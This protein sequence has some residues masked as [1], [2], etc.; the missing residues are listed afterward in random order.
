MRKQTNYFW[1]AGLGFLCF[2]TKIDLIQAQITSDRTLSTEV[3]T[4]NNLDFT[5]INGNRVGNNLF[6]SFRELSVP[7]GGSAFFSNDLNVQNIISRVTGGSISNIDGLLK[8]NG[9][10]NLFLI[11]PNGIIFGQNASLNINGSFFVST[12]NN[13]IFADGTQFS[14]TNLQTP[15]LLTVSVPIG[16]QFG[17]IAQPIQIYGSTLE[18]VVPGNTLAILGGDVLVKGG[19][20]IAPGGRI[21]I[22]S[23][24]PNSLVSLNPISE[25][26]AFG[27]EGVQNF[28]DIQLSQRALI[29]TSGEGSGGIQLRGRDIAIADNSQIARFTLGNKPGQPLVIK[30]SE[31]VEISNNSQ[32]LTA[33]GQNRPASDIEIETKRLIVRDGAFIDAS[34]F[35]SGAGGNITVNAS[36]SVQLLG[37][38]F[39]T[40]LGTQSLGRNNNAG[41]AGTVNIS[42]GKLILRD[43]GRILTSTIGSGNAGT[44]RID[45]S[46]SVEAS[47]ISVLDRNLPSGLLAET[48]TRSS[49][50][51]IPAT[52]NG[53]DLIINTQRLLVQNG[54]SISTAAINGSRGQAGRLDIN[55]SNSVT[56]TGTGIDG[57]GQ[58]VRST[59]L[60][61]SDGFGNAGDLR[62]NTNKLTVQDGAAISVASTGFG[63]AGNLEITS[64]LIL[65]DNQGKLTANTQ[66]GEGNINLR[67]LNLI[68]RRGSAIT[69]NATGN[70]ITGGNINID[71]NN[72]FI[73]AVKS[74]N[75]DISANSADFRG[76]NVTINATGIF[77]TQFRNAA[78][79][80]SEITA[81][82]ANPSLSG[83]VQ[84]NTPDLDPTRG[85]L[86]LSSDLVDQSHLITQG[87]PANR[88]D[89]FIITGRGGL[90]PLPNE[91]LRSNQTATVNWVTQGE[92]R[93]GGE[94]EKITK[95][96]DSKLPN[97]IVPATGWVINDNGDVTL[98]ASANTTFQ[99]LTP[100][101]CPGVNIDQN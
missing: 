32:L 31:T 54:A 82:G 49:K 28:Q 64:G 70:N 36:E 34:T 50:V 46:E 69:T 88:G 73:V 84:I 4:T 99:S 5:I 98:I 35:G 72:G 11:N 63:N 27:Y 74:E 37:N 58:I 43:G 71:A 12:A 44:L 7:T 68:L 26:S 40:S 48:T 86:K 95:V 1:I 8:T 18:Q 93:R 19:R 65:L 62:V 97:Q 52:G 60:A 77:G 56:V 76:G 3:L 15:P 21:D 94:E 80:E 55:A 87:C 45:A 91:A 6:H 38:G 22:G 20:L 75:S 83:N 78:T 89:V 61:A 33:T 47:G 81:T 96:S 10:A 41:N 2:L 9:S 42:T 57:N 29:N 14:A 25:G 59:L 24:A 39:Y 90:P 23:V 16:L 100:T 92:R 85:L 79:L 13:I 53:G 17:Q 101:T 66:A 67:S 30:A 51:F